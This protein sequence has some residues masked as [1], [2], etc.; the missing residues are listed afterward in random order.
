MSILTINSQLK[1]VARRIGRIAS[2]R[3]ES[4]DGGETEAKV[5]QNDV[6]IDSDAIK[7]CVVFEI[8]WTAEMVAHRTRQGRC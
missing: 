7:K 5:Y 3:I 6:D 2:N 1:R 8:T 4:I